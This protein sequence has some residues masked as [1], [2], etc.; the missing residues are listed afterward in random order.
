MPSRYEVR[1]FVSRLALLGNENCER[2]AD[3]FV[4]V[5]DLPSVVETDRKAKPV[6]LN[7]LLNLR[8]PVFDKDTDKSDRH[9]YS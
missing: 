5:S 1:P 3:K 2:R 7:K 9:P 6:G 8:L 4:R